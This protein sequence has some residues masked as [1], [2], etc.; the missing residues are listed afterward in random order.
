MK[1]LLVIS[2]FIAINAVSQTLPNNFVIGNFIEL[3]NQDS[4]KIFFSCTGTV[5]DK[6]CANYYR[7][8][9]VD[10]E[11]INIKG[12]FQDFYVDGHLLLSALMNNNMLNGYAKYYSKSGQLKE[13]GNYFNDFR[14]GK[15]TYYHSNGNVEKI[16]DYTEEEPIIL[17]Y[18]SKNGKPKV[19]NG[20]GQYKTEFSNYKAC[21]HYETWGEVLNGKRN[22]KWVFY[23][24]PIN[25]KISTEIYEEG[26]FIK[27]YSSGSNYY[28]YDSPKISFQKFYANENLNLA[29]NL[30]GCPGDYIESWLYKNES[31]MSIF[32]HELNSAL[33]SYPNHAENQWLIVGIQINE[34]NTISELNVASSI[35]DSKLEDYISSVISKMREWKSAIIN[36]EPATSDIFFTIFVYNDQIIIPTEYNN[37]QQ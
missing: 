18:Y 10:P 35:D 34:N 3:F 20:N 13:E 23:N 4:V 32:Y 9:K 31:L 7:I 30:L 15:W 25:Q 14:A 8:G 1:K 16:I 24:P 36:S 5:V 28:E 33:N 29:E 21:E 12:E 2:F 19:I 17:E 11:F 22:G 6:N 26:K 37:R 27:G